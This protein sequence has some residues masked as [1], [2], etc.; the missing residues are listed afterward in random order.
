MSCFSRNF[1]DLGHCQHFT[2]NFII[3]IMKGVAYLN[4]VIIMESEENLKDFRKSYLPKVLM[5]NIISKVFSFTSSYLL[6]SRG[7][8]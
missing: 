5:F 4:D 6:S 7:T 2:E 3:S 8:L 1:H